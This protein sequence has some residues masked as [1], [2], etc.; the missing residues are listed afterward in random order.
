VQGE[1]VPRQNSSSTV[2]TTTVLY[3]VALSA[4]PYAYCTIQSMQVYEVALP[5]R[6]HLYGT[7]SLSIGDVATCNDIVPL[8]YSTHST[9]C[10]VQYTT[11]LISQGRMTV[12]R[13]AVP[14]RSLPRCTVH[15]GAYGTHGSTASSCT[16]F[17]DDLDTILT[18][19]VTEHGVATIAYRCTVLCNSVYRT[20]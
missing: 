15:T 19:T 6:R 3:A 14:R 7:H 1:L 20:C 4:V 5:W 2:P 17:L 9:G 16:I 10:A 11:T 13:L 18:S 12:S 8:L